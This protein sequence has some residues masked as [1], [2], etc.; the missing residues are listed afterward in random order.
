MRLFR[1][2]CLRI[3]RKEKIRSVFCADVKNKFPISENNIPK[4]I[5]KRPK[6]VYNDAN[7]SNRR[8]KQERPLRRNYYGNQIQEAHHPYGHL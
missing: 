4:P 1:L 7:E 8:P 3:A 5:D 6:K 2:F